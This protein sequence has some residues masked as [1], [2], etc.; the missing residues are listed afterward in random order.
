[1]VLAGTELSFFVKIRM[2][3]C[4]EFLLMMTGVLVVTEQ[5]LTDSRTTLAVPPARDLGC[6][7]SCEGTEPGQLT[8]TGQRDEPYHLAI[9]AGGKEEEGWVF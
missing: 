6:T 4:F 8:P 2:I 7:T 1:M 5:L 3:L 9:K